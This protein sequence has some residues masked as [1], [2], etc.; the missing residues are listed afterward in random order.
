MNTIQIIG[1][2]ILL[3]GFIVQVVLFLSLTH[4]WFNPIL[5]QKLL[6]PSLIVT[7]VGFVIQL[8]GLIGQVV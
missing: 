2:V 6:K 1:F 8:T 5:V 7:G 4:A 3:I